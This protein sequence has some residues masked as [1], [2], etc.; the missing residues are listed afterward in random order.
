MS[1]TS[2]QSPR[3]LIAAGGTGGHIFPALAVWEAL[4]AKHPELA[5]TWLGSSHRMESR[6]IPARGIEFIGLRQTEFRRRP[7]PANIVYNARS[8]LFLQSAIWQAVGI[9]WKLKP[10]L[11]LT[12][13]GFAGGAAGLAAWM[14]RTP[15][16][17]IEPN[18][19]PGLTNRFLGRR[20]A[21]V[22]VTYPEA[23]EYFP[24]TK[25]SVVGTPSRREVAEKDR[26]EAR[27]ALG[28][29]NQTLMI[30]AMGGSQGAAGINKNLPEAVRLATKDRPGIRFRVIH[31]CGQG[32]FGA[33]QV[34]RASLSENQYQ[35]MEFIDDAPT[36]LAAAD[37]IVS[38]AGASTLAEIAC[39]GIPSI[40]IPYPFSSENHQVKNARSWEA[41]GAAF[42]LEE[43]DLAPSALATSLLLLLTDPS[44]RE[45]MGKEAMKFGDPQAANRIAEML[46]QW[47]VD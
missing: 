12:T 45:S 36:Y 41:S 19:F 40:L 4:S 44:K 17:I 35:V 7:T 8:L 27:R 3:I 37:L 16:A 39:R 33:I 31:Q 42:C 18:V 29:D 22:F 47:I 38:R 24:P 30:L 11:V 13:G 20:A 28:I 1:S 5:L 15:L 34:D 26:M 9:I 43:K 32:K 25:A 21:R 6:L 14:T 10:R 46:E 2:G 23:R